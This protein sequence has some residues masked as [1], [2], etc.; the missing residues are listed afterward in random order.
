MSHANLRSD[1]IAGNQ[2]FRRRSDGVA[3]ATLSTDGLIVHSLVQGATSAHDLY[4]SAIPIADEEDEVTVWN[5]EGGLEI[6]T[7]GE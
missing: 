1:W 4:L 5:N 6:S 2:V 7:D 3:I